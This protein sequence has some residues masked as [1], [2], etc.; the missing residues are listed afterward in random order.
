MLGTILVGIL[1]GLV[2]RRTHPSG[3][4]VGWIG[5]PVLGTAG[6]LAAFYGGRAAHLFTDG[7]MLAWVAAM[8]GAASVVGVWGVVK[9][10]R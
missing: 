2:A 1:V 5:A 3:R 7:Q 8:A 10:R 6:A 9:G 4:T